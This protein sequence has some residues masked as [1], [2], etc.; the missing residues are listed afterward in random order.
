MSPSLSSLADATAFADW[1]GG[2]F[3]VVSIVLPV[4]FCLALIC[5]GISMFAQRLRA[6]HRRGIYLGGR[7][8][9]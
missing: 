6:A 4:V 3:L 2:L 8:A 9:R 1:L 7:N 5:G